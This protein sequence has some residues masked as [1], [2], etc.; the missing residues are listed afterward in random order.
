MGDSNMS[1]ISPVRFTPE[2][3]ASF[4]KTELPV[5]KIQLNTGLI[6]TMT[7]GSVLKTG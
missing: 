5:F 3:A 1:S 4:S 7:A 2:L 6:L